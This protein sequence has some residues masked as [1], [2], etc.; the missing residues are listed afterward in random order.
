[1]LK[2]VEQVIKVRKRQRVLVMHDG[3][4]FKEHVL[5]DLLLYDKF[6]SLDSYMIVQDTKMTRMYEPLNGNG[7]P[8][9]AAAEFMATQGEGRYVVDKQYEY[10]I[11]SQHHNGWLKKVKQ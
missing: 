8:L 10:S 7:Y 11:Y 4:H 5:Q 3:S 2:K 9:R 1:M 6:V